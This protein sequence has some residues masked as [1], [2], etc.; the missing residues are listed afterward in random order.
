MNRELLTSPGSAMGTVVTCLRTARGKPL[1]ARTDLFSSELCSTNGDR[2]LAFSS[3]T[4]ATVFDAILRRAPVAPIRLNPDLP[5]RLEDI[6]N[7]AL[8]KDR[9]LRYQH[10]SEMRTDL[11]R[12]KRDTESVKVAVVDDEEELA[13][14]CGKQ[15]QVKAVAG[16]Q[17]TVHSHHLQT[18]GCGV[19]R[20]SVALAA[21]LI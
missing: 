3:D 19:R 7:K 21:A 14:L 1:D 11:Q 20:L 16:V 9:N 5:S 2:S 4:T 8:E 17:S 10:A 18:C 13:I 15:R 6:I 12:L